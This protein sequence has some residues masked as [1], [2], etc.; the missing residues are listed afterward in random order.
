DQ[1]RQFPGG[2]DWKAAWLVARVDV[3]QIG[4]AVARH[5]VMIERLAEL[6]RGED[7]VL[8][9]SPGRAFDVG[10]PVFDRL[11]QRMGRGNPMRQLELDGLVFG[12][13]RSGRERKAEKHRSAARQHPAHGFPPDIVIGYIL[14][15]SHLNAKSLTCTEPRGPWGVMRKAALS[16]DHVQ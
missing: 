13:R 11:L 7:L 8:D 15:G 2:D 10:A 6:L 14:N 4:D 9:S 5:I 16:K 12:K 3:G 1:K